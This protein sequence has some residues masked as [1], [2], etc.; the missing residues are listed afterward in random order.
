MGEDAVSTSLGCCR[1]E[2]QR[3]GDSAHP[4]SELWLGKG[5]PWCG[6]PLFSYSMGV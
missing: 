6:N 1:S 2:R 3:D 5:D 4:L